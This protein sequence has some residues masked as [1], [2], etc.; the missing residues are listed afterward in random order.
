MNDYS[1]TGNYYTIG[2]LTLFTGLSDRTIRTY[3]SSGILEGEKIN[4]L[5]HFT[6]EQVDAFLRHPAVRPSIT[7]KNNA[8]IYDFLA[9]TKKA[10]SKSCVIL[11]CPDCDEKELTAFF[12]HAICSDPAL[13]DFRF[14][15]DSLSGTPRVILT[16]LTHQVLDLVNRYY[17]HQNS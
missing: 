4:N 12:H 2:H 5:W 15:F 9:D 11:D 7:A 16:G 1:A 17:E 6:P 14:S 8:L 13:H 10:A 3:L